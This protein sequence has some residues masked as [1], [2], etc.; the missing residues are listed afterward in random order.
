[1]T[2]RLPKLSGVA[3]A[4]SPVGIERHTRETVDAK[5]AERRIGDNCRCENVA[6]VMR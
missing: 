4:V 2:S 3:E 5:G 1:M 6:F